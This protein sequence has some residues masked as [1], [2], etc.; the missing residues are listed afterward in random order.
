MLTVLFSPIHRVGVST[1]GNYLACEVAKDDLTLYIEWSDSTGKSMYINNS[2]SERKRCLSNAVYST[3]ELKNN[4]VR[5]RHNK[6]LFYLC[7]N[8]TNTVLSLKN[9]S[10][11]ALYRIVKEAQKDF[12]H[13]IIDLPA[14]LREQVVTYTFSRHFHYIDNI[15]VVLDEDAL[16]FKKLHDFSAILNLGHED[17]KEITY[18]INKTTQYYVDFIDKSLNLPKLKPI[19]LLKI[20]DFSEMSDRTNRGNLYSLAGGRKYKKFFKEIDKLTDICLNNK[21]GYGIKPIYV[22]EASKERRLGAKYVPPKEPKLKKSFFKN[23]KKFLEEDNSQ[24][25]GGQATSPT[26]NDLV[27]STGIDNNNIDD[28]FETLDSLP[29]EDYQLEQKSIL[30]NMQISDLQASDIQTTTSDIVNLDGKDDINM[31]DEP[32]SNTMKDKIVFKNKFKKGKLFG[33]NHKMTIQDDISTD[34]N[35]LEPIREEGKESE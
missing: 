30:D 16:T 23:K 7:Q 13:I 33:K 6:N 34:L 21:D 22:S 24:V 20:E 18:I 11:T 8:I 19:N 2:I 4:L 26:Q 28:L 12:K 9:Y 1:I 17:A 27:L 32:V 25:G 10:Q 15:V 29:E 14:D 31:V 35:N 5:S 3:A